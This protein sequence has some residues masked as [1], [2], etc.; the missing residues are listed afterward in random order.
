M[1]VLPALADDLH[2]FQAGEPIQRGRWAVGNVAGVGAGAIRW[3]R[4]CRPP[5]CWC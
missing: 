5:Y 2:R 1:G 4:G 3:R